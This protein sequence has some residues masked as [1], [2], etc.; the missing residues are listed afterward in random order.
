MNKKVNFIK[1]KAEVIANYIGNDFLNLAEELRDLQEAKP[2][3]CWRG[4]G[5][6]GLPLLAT[7]RG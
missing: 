5:S 7:L 1:D 2:D 3:I 6:R 4:C